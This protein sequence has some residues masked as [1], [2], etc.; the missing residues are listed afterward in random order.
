MKGQVSGPGETGTNREWN[1]NGI[2]KKK[3][4]L[5]EGGHAGG[6]VKNRRIKQCPAHMN[7]SHSRYPKEETDAMEHAGFEPASRTF[8]FRR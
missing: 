8:L 5:H 2:G 6:K 4:P 3:I 7:K 1:G